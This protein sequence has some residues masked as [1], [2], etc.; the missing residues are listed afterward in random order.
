MSTITKPTVDEIV[1]ALL[2]NTGT[3]D[4][5]GNEARLFVQTVRRL[6]QGRPLTDGDV[7]EIS[8][9]LDLTLEQANDVLNWLV[10]Q[11]DDGEI[12][13]IAG[14]SLNEWKSWFSDE[15]PRFHYLVCAGHAVFAANHPARCRD[16]FGRPY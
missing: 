6:A 4:L 16:K 11:N 8:A 10:E 12:A 15:R 14:L 9:G 7:E 2:R 3:I 1:A 13:G 5:Q